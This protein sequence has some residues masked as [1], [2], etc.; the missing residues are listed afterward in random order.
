M[1]FEEH[2]G[3]QPTVKTWSQCPAEIPKSCFVEPEVLQELQGT[4]L[5]TD[6]EWVKD[7]ASSE[8]SSMVLNDRKGENYDSKDLWVAN[9]LNKHFA[10]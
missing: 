5:I 1:S 4:R 8:E 2:R 10:C 7:A 6:A 9:N 3:L